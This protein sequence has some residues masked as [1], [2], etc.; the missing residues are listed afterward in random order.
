M[1]KYLHVDES[2][3]THTGNPAKTQMMDAMLVLTHEMAMATLQMQ[4][5]THRRTS[6]ALPELK[7]QHIPLSL[8][9]TRGPR[10]NQQGPP[11]TAG[12]GGPSAEH[13]KDLPHG[14]RR[15]PSL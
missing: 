15:G 11:S 4:P 10:N 3:I 12:A 1:N 9:S 5:L 7:E 6:T 14:G 13:K 2:K 8:A